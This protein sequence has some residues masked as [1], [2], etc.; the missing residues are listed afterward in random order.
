MNE[1]RLKLYLE[2]V[3]IRRR[4]ARIRADTANDDAP[5]RELSMSGLVERSTRRCPMRAS[6]GPAPG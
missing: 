3:G 6:R 1:R 5:E 2:V 4:A